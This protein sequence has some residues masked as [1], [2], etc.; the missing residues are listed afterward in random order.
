MRFGRLYVKSLTLV[1]THTHACLHAHTYTFNTLFVG[2]PT[3]ATTR[4]V[5]SIWILLKQETVSGSCISWA[6]CKS[7][8]RSRQITAPARH[9]SVLLAGALPAV[10]PNQQCQSTEGQHKS[11]R[12]EKL[13]AGHSIT[14]FPHGCLPHLSTPPL[15]LFVVARPRRRIPTRK[16]TQDLC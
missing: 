8:P 14:Y 15:R 6:T 4:K 2:L 1:Y 11:F 12:R 5:K 7:A 10:P 9:Y 13:I 3:W 16:T